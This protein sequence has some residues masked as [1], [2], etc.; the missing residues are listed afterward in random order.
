[1]HSI[2]QLSKEKTVKKYSSAQ[3][4][5]DLLLVIINEY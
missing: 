5:I 4:R 2:G 1:M 3:R